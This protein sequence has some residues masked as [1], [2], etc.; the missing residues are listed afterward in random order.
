MIFKSSRYASTGVYDVRTP[1]G[2]IVR[3][4]RIREIPARPAG[5][6]HR[7]HD[8]DRLDLLAFRFYRNPEKFWLIADANTQMDPEDLTQPGRL[9][10]IPPD[11]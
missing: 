3:A 5:F 1:D 2:Q 7:F 6:V 9:V 11:A 4:L 10:L 8:S